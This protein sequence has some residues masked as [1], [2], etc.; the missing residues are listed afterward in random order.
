MMLGDIV[1]VDGVYMD[2]SSADEGIEITYHK[3]GYQVLGWDG[4]SFFSDVK[5]AVIC[6]DLDDAVHLFAKMINEWGMYK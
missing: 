4:G 1:K 6:E 5:F 2:I 3:D